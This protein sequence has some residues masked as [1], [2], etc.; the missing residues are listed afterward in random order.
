NVDGNILDY[1]G[2]IKHM[3]KQKEVIESIN[4]EF[5]AIAEDGENVFTNHIVT[6]VKKDGD[7]LKVKVIAQFIIKNNLIVKCDE[8]T[9]MLSGKEADRDMGSRH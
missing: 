9:H 5:L 2:F 4:V 7:K 6:A 1:N 8:L 3:K